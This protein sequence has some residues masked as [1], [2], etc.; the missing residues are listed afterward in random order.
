MQV[1]VGVGH[2]H[3]LVAR[4]LEA[5]FSRS[6]L[7]R[8]IESRTTSSARVARRRRVGR[9]RGLVSGAVVEDQHLELRVVDRQCGL[10]TG[11]ITCSS[12]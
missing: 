9:G 8:L 12:L 4:G 3:E 1:R 2:D 7:P 5:E 6:A 10:D 11:P